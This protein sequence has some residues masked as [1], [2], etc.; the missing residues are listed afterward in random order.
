MAQN[1][2]LLSESFENLG[3]GSIDGETL[4]TLTGIIE[5]T[6]E[7]ADIP[8][9][10]VQQRALE[11]IVLLQSL[12]VVLSESDFGADEILGQSREMVGGFLRDIN[13]LPE[14]K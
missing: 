1:N 6:R 8:I 12:Y 3:I 11:S 2:E 7:E 13:R 14:E 10:I 9:D 4:P 5:I